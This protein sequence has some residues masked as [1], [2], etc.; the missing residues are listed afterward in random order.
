[1]SGYFRESAEN[2]R[3]G[4]LSV[5]TDGVAN[6]DYVHTSRREDGIARVN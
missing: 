5:Q 6:I 1:M 4:R 2:N 3:A